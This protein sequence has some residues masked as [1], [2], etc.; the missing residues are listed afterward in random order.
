MKNRILVVD[1][2]KSNC[3][4]INRILAGHD[5]EMETV[6]MHWIWFLILSLIRSFWIS[7]CRESMGMRFAVG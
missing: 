2:D 4:L 1:D 5:Y 6:R 7:R 3:R